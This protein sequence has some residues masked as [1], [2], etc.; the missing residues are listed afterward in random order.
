LVT[1]AGLSTE[2]FRPGGAH[3][4]LGYTHTTAGVFAQDDWTLGKKAILEAGARAD[5]VHTLYFLPR[6][7]LLYRPLPGLTARLGGGLAYKLP[8]VFNSSDEEEAY[9]QVYPIDPGV[10]AERSASV[11]LSL[12][13]RC[14]LDDEIVFSADQNF[15]YTRL[16][17]ALVPQSDSL[18]R[19]WLFYFNAPGPLVSRGLETNAR[20]TIDHLSL[21][22]GYTYT[23]VRREYL[24]DHPQLP[25]TPRHRLVSNLTY[26]VEPSWK[27]GVDAFYTG[28]QV[29][30][31]AS[32]TRAFWTFDLM[33]QRSWGHYSLLL[34]LENL[35]DTRQSR[36]GS[37]YTGPAQCPVFG[38]VYAPVEGRIVSVAFRYSL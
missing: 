20:L 30:D 16:T 12:N 27:M 26:E 10:R 31:D 14:R 3:G 19:G 28:S 35:T 34:N 7:A 24:P 25:L 32:T 2:R 6:L 23:D 21:Y 29:L 15:Y 38:E 22:V 4:G 13:Y 17:N 1:G 33:L 37:L 11:N 5:W 9:Q 8:T 18:R 36:W